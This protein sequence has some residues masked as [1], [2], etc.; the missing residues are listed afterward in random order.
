MKKKSNIVLN[1][2][3]IFTKIFD[4]WFDLIEVHN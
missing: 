3:K 1:I 2:S 4:R